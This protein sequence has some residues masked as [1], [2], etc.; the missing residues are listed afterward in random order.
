MEPR[1]HTLTGH[2]ARIFQQHAEANTLA[3]PPLAG[4]ARAEEVSSALTRA[5][6]RRLFPNVNC[7]LPKHDQA[8]EIA[9]QYVPQRRVRAHSRCV[10]MRQQCRTVRAGQR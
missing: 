5:L 2:S 9:E 8:I 4:Y 1:G 10:R 6:M 7:L 3:P